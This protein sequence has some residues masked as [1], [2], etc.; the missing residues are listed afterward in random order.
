MKNEK[1]SWEDFLFENR[2]K[3]YGAYELRTSADRT[4][5]KSLLVVVFTLGIIITAFSSTE[6][7]PMLP[8]DRNIP[9]VHNLKK[10]EDEFV[11]P[12][13]KPIVEKPAV[14][15][16]KKKSGIDVAPTP[17][18][19]PKVEKPIAEQKDLGVK[20]GPEQT[21]N[22][23]DLGAY[24]PGGEIADGNDT[25]IGKNN[26]DNRPNGLV[27]DTKTV[28]VREVTQMAVFPGCEKVANTKKEL[29]DCMSLK[30]KEEIGNQLSDFSMIAEK[31]NLTKVKAQLNFVVDK[32]GRIVQIHT[33][34][35]GDKILG[36]EAQKALD[37]ISRRM[38]Q[39]Q[40][41]IKPAQMSDGTEVN[42]LFSIPVSFERN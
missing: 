14:I 40:K 11:K 34:G 33:V 42:M 28:N 18:N 8:Y 22:P 6:K 12:P 23:D 29:T 1:Q 31:N 36:T 7:D 38:I 26:G 24:N 2:N 32:N 13:A 5:L 41:F 20:E 4:L 17:V 16:V 9:P 10:I 27:S 37:R 35:N 21:G 39:K 19:E 15:T 3:S 25:G 30:L